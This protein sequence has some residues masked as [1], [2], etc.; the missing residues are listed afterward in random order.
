[1][2]YLKS[3]GRFLYDFYIGDDWKTAAGVVVVLGIGA[4]LVATGAFGETAIALIVTAG[5]ALAFAANLIF[6]VRSRQKDGAQN[7]Q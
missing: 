2:K 6:D 1:M 3:L 5:I 4:V 7:E